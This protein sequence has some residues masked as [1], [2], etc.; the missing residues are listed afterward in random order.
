[1]LIIKTGN[2]RYTASNFIRHD[3]FKTVTTIDLPEDLPEDSN[4]EIHFNPYSSLYD[5]RNYE[6]KHPCKAPALFNLWN[7]AR[8]HKGDE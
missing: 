7:M 8:V 6:G 2:T 3:G 4:I 5:E 1:M